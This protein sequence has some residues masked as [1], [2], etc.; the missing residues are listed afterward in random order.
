MKE[1]YLQAFCCLRPGRDFLRWMKGFTQSA[2]AALS[3]G[4]SRA[5]EERH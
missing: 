1:L 5:L 4:V 3:V 2:K